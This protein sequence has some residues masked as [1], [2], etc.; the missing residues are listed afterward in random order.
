MADEYKFIITGKDAT[1]RAFTAIRKNLGAVRAGVNSTQ[2]KVAALAGAAGLGALVA[3]SLSSGDALGKFADRVG[4][5]TEGLAGLQ[6]IT[7]LNGESSESLSKSLEKMNRGVGEAQRGIGTALPAFKQLGLNVE[8]LAQL[9]ADERFIQIGDAIGKLDDETLQA[10]LSADIFGRSGVRLINTF[11]QGEDAMRGATDQA[12]ELGIAMSRTDAAKIEAAN[13]AM[14]LAN[15]RIEGI[16]N[17]VT[18]ALA[19]IIAEVADQFTAAGMSSNEMSDVIQKGMKI[20]ASVVGTFADGLHGVQVILKGVEVAGYGFSTA[21]VAGIKLV[22]DASFGFANVIRD[23]WLLP[24]RG[25]ISAAQHLPGISD[26]TRASLSS[27]KSALD[28]EWRPPEAINQTLTALSD[29]LTNARGELHQMM[30]EDLPS[31]VIDE[32]LAVVLQNAEAK[33][34]AIAARAQTRLDTPDAEGDTGGVDVRE[35]ERLQGRLESLNA[36]YASE[37]ELLQQKLT[38]EQTLLQE[39]HNAN[40]LT[41]QRFQALNIRAEKR[42]QAEKSK[43]EAKSASDRRAKL[44]GSLTEI[45]NMF[46]GQSKKMFKLQKTLALAEAV[47]TLPPAI[48]SSYKN[49]G[50]FPLGI[51]AAIA[52]AAKG[53]AQ[54]ASIKSTSLGSP[55]SITN[56]SGGGGFSSGTSGLP[57]AASSANSIVDTIG[58]LSAD[59]N[60]SSN[61]A[62]TEVHFHFPDGLT[63]GTDAEQNLAE[64]RRIIVEEDFELIPADSRNGIDL[65]TARGVA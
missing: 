32:R 34:E 43:L 4:A 26:E 29:G 49:A 24:M 13:D 62:K 33:A 44:F 59:G 38:T 56:P 61:Q 36:S 42:Y 20:G 23:T 10:S 47:V 17:Q 57:S 11:E 18:V 41:E 65:A 64:M 48:I 53:A 21:F 40:L 63:V 19:P 30:L 55:G 45:A 46:G 35:Q 22:T 54:I 37:L 14:L 3:K 25:L 9:P 1:K 27:L 7:E 5:T 12:K 16:G 28:T 15:K 51:P 39:S 60:T 6:L 2:V 58:S 8:E 31:A 50:G 52:M